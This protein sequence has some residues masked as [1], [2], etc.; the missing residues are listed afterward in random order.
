MCATLTQ[1]LRSDYQGQ[2]CSIARGLEL[3][4]ERWTLLIIR[5]VFR[6]KR[7]FEELQHSLG[8]ARNVLT[9]RLARLVEEDLLERR[10][11]SERPRRDE[12]FLTEKG[13]DLWPVLVTLMHWGDEHFSDG[14][15]PMIL[16]HKGDCGGHVNERGI[17]ESC[18]ELLS[19]RDARIIDGPGMPEKFRTTD[20]PE[21]PA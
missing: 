18:G 17:C 7:R 21:V 14:A 19:A 12:Y 20:A 16:L 4:G 5:D 2:I 11:Y 8:I 13:L 10:P 1:M 3:V 6:G 9:S 15:P